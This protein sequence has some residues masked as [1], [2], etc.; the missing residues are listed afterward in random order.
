MIPENEYAPY[1]K[2]YIQQIEKNGKS[3]VENLMIAQEN[4]QQSLQNISEEKQHFA[5]ASE[6]WNMKEVVQHIIDTERV[7]CYR[8]L[9]FARNDKTSLPGFDQDLF[10]A[11]VNAN[12]INWADLLTEMAIVRQGTILLFKS[13]SEESL[14][15]IGVG[16]EKNMSVRAIGFLCSGHQIHHLNILKERYF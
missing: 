9:C 2:N 10:V 13:F 1:Y 12:T 6:K 11:N 8:A 15:R 5:Y 3:I 14:K 4:F 7:F 16:S